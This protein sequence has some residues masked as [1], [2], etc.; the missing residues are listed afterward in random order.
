MRVL[1]VAMDRLLELLLWTALAG[2][3][4]P[5]GAGLGRIEHLRP[6]WLEEE[7][8]PY[9]DNWETSVQEREKAAKLKMLLFESIS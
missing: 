1:D 3:C 2:A 6:Q 4:I 7:F 8:I 9:L 5:L